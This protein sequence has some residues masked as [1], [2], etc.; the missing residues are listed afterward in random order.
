M[1]RELSFGLIGE[2]LPHSYS[3]EIHKALADYDYRLC[4]LTPDELTYFMEQKHFSGINVTIP[5]KKAVIPYLTDIDEKAQKIGAVNTIVNRNGKL[6]GY[7]TDY[8]GLKALFDRID[9]SIRGKNCI[10]LGTGGTSNTARAVLSD[11]GAKSIT[12]VSRTPNGE[13]ISYEKARQRKDTEILV[14]TTPCGMFPHPNESPIDLD[15]FP[16]LCGVVDAVYNPL[17][18]ELVLQAE[19][20]NVPSI[21][22]LYM[23]A[24]Q[25]QAASEL[26]LGNAPKIDSDKIETVYRKIRN[27]KENIVLIGMPSCGKS[28]VGKAAADALGREF[29]DADEEFCRQFGIS[30]GEFIRLN[31]EEAFRKKESD[32]IRTISNVSGSVIATGGGAVLRDENI[33]VLRRNGYIYF[34]DRDPQKLLCGGDRPLSS[35][36]ASLMKLYEVRLPLYRKSCD[37]V[38]S[39]EQ[40]IAD[41]LT[42]LLTDWNRREDLT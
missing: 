11:E 39:S 36:C 23:L 14:N 37:R 1:N 24:A 20:R 4:E 5:Y 6:Y 21:G 19:K 10:I 17:R 22:G 26:F 29:F 30:A 41:T 13:S 15:A 42:A 33:N 9:V 32:V 8:Y 40:T 31:G 34:L 27:Q 25:A 28:T 7:N 35:D 3:A 12:V 2:K 18:T 16:D 38:L